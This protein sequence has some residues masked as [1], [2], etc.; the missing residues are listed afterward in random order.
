MPIA[1]GVFKKL[2]LKKQAALGTIAAP[3]AGGTARYMRRVKSTLD[4][5][6]A[7]FKS[8]EINISQQ[9]RDFRHGVRSVAGSISGELSV[10][11]YQLPLESV[12]R[13]LST[14]GATTGSVAT[15]TVASSGAGT[16][17]GTLTRSAGDYI[18]DGFKVGDVVRQTGGSAGANNAHN[19]LITA[20]T[21]TVMTVRTLDA[22]D[23]I[24]QAAAAGVTVQ[25]AGK[26]TFVPQT[27]HNRDYYTIEHFYG[28]LGES[29]RFTDCVFTGT[30]ITFPNTGMATIEL[31]VMGLNV[32]TGQAE[33]FTT[34][35]AAPLGPVVA[36][37]NGVLLVNGT[38]VADVTALSVSIVGA[39]AA[40]GGVVGANVDPDIFPGVLEV[41]GSMTVL[42]R[43]AVLRDLFYNET[44][45][46]IYGAFTGD[47]TAGAGFVA[48]GMPRVKASANTKDDGQSML[49]QTIPFQ[50]LE[51]INGGAA[52]NTEATTITIQDSAFV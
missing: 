25:V 43:S 5:A 27:G 40:P 49:S 42:F 1:T 34:P 13:R 36:A 2:S 31:P 29:E 38:L 26:K 39:Y 15:I 8:A 19:F 6:K 17:A 45:F 47:N 3:G 11:G 21:S 12:F 28:D 20:L 51:N 33:Y 24:A 16:Y 18:A 37:S 46:G 4:L 48:I 44:E 14:A 9:I 30:T 22:T 23:L 35:A 32:Q 50:A 10:G 7:T 41:T 52:V